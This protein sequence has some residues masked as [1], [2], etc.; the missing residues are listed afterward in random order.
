M[1]HISVYVTMGTDIH[2]IT[3]HLYVRISMNVSSSQNR[4]LLMLTVWILSAAL[5]TSVLVKMVMRV[6]D[7]RVT[8]S[9]S[10]L[11]MSKTLT[12]DR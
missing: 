5:S 6:T 3:H 2:L 12:A 1:D 10:Y 4:V 9:V 8:V 7:R 11:Y